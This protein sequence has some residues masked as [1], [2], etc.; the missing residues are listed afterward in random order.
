MGSMLS[1]PPAGFDGKGDDGRTT[2]R[3]I[4]GDC[5]R[6]TVVLAGCL[7]FTRV[8]DEKTVTVESGTVQ[9]VIID[10]QK[11]DLQVTVTGT[12]ADVSVN[13]CLVTHDDDNDASY[14]QLMAGKAPPKALASALAKKDF[15]R[16]ATLPAGK[17]GVVLLA[18]D[19]KGD[20]KVTIVGKMIGR[21]RKDNST[22]WFS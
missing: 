11:S 2:A 5:W 15:T 21:G 7:K 3:G 13:A 4:H 6:L 1:R 16:E 9:K 19:K 18:S 22:S 10:P 12:S 17:E 14:S 8:K 20:V